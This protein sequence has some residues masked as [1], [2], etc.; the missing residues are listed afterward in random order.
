MNHVRMQDE[1]SPELDQQE[2]QK[3]GDRRADTEE[4][5]LYGEAS[6]AISHSHH[7]DALL[8]KRNNRAA[9]NFGS[10]DRCAATNALY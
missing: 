3:H 8:L 2:D 10:N 1:K 7:D 4:A 5:R 6:V 9:P